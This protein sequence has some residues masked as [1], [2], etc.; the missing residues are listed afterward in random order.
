M[1][2]AIITYGSRGDVQ[3]YIALALGLIDCGHK[4]TLLA[5][6]NFKGFVEGYGVS[7]HPLHGNLEALAYSPEVTRIL[8]TGNAFSFLRFMQKASIKLQPQVNRDMLAGCANADVLIANILTALWVRAIAEK[9]NKQWGLF[10]VSFP[11]AYTKEFPFAGLA[12]FNFPLYNLFTYKFV[13]FFY[14]QLNKRAVNEFRRSLGLSALKNPTPEKMPD[15][16]ILNLY[17]VSPYLIARPKDWDSNTDITGYLTLPAGKRK[18]SLMDQVPDGLTAWLQ[19]GEKPIYIG[20]GSIP[21]PDAQKLSSILTYIIT[22]ANQRI[23]FCMGW[24]DIPG[25]PKHP[26]LFVVKYIN[27]EWL[28]P[29]C[30]TAVIHGGAGTT[31]T[32]LKAKIPV[33][34][35]SVAADQPWWGKVIQ[36]K[37]LGVHIPFKKLTA[38]KLLN[39]IIETQ[40]PEMMKTAIETGE[41]INREDGLNRAINAI[42]KYFD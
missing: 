20:F 10:Q 41:N 39:A 33:I 25:L 6:E 1:H 12:F 32:A 24:S 29:Q 11:T 38:N 26:N 9:F 34:I 23:I 27:H 36:D 19:N 16:N 15:H 22:K 13:A 21:V 17:A 37:K 35:V 30:K 28:F 14:W 40:K 2:Y 31:A 42:E 18:T 4:A 5:P 7:F 3:P 8:K